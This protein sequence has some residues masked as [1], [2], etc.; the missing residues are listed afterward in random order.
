MSQ[1]DTRRS[2]V[3]ALATTRALVG[4]LSG[5]VVISDAPTPTFVVQEHQASRHHYDL[6]LEVDGV[7]KSWA[8][9][10]GPSMDPGVKRLAVQVGDHDMAAG[11]FEG[12]HE[13]GGGSVI[14][15][16]RGTYRNT[17]IDANGAEVTMRDALEQGRV[18]IRLV[19]TKLAGG[20]L[21]VRTKRKGPKPS[22]LLIKRNDEK[23][24]AGLEPTQSHRA[25]VVSGLTLR[26][27]SREERFKQP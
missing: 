17:K 4:C 1:F 13:G 6:R 16:D 7:L 26:E 12:I 14:I 20:Y 25:S 18:E 10:K 2:E 24:E 8:V 11:S 9:P 22:W 27:F 15:W 19:G 5:G 21:L 3:A 23:A